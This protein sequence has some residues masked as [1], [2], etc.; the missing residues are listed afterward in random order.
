[1]QVMKIGQIRKLVVTAAAIWLILTSMEIPSVFAH[2]V[3]GTPDGDLSYFRK[4]DH[5]SNPKNTIYAPYPGSA[6]HVPGPLAY[7]WPGSG[8]NTYL[9]DPSLPPGYQSPFEDFEQ[10]PQVACCQYSPEAAILASTSDQDVVGDFV[11]GMN[12]SKP[13]AFPAPRFFR[14]WSMVIYIPAP[15][16]NKSGT[17]EQDGFEPIGINWDLGETTNIVTTLTDSYGNISVTRAGPLDPFGPNWWMIRI[18]AGGKGIVFTEEGNEWYYVR[19]NQMR[20]PVISGRYFF[21]I[22]LDEHYPV[23]NQ[24]D[25]SNLIKATVPVENWPV[26]LVKGDID[27]A[28]VYGTV[29]YGGPNQT[30]YGTPLQLPGRIRLAGATIGLAN[31]QAPRRAVEA[32]GY[33]NASSKGHY[34]VEGVSPGTYDVYASAAGFPEQTVTR[35]IRVM[36]GQS[37]ALDLYLKPGAEVRGDLFAKSVLSSSNWAQEFP[38]NIVIYSSDD[39][40]ENSIVTF[41]PTNLTHSPYTSYVQGNTVF[42]ILQTNP[43]PYVKGGLLASNQPKL[44][45]FPWQGPV[46]Y[47]PYTSNPDA[48]DLYGIFNGVGPAQKWWVSPSGS[49]D[50]VTNLGSTANSFRFQFGARYI[51]GTPTRLSGMIPQ[52]FATWI[53]GLGI[54]TYFLRAYVHEY[55]QTKSDGSSFEDYSFRISSLDQYVGVHVQMDLYRAG[56]VD[57]V[58]HFHDSPGTRQDSNIGG[59]DPTRYI[60]VEAFDYLGQMSALNFTKVASSSS[61]AKISLTGLGMAGVILPPDPRSGVKYSLLRYRGVRDYGLS[62]GA[63]SIRVYVRGYVQASAPGNTLQHL[64][65][66]LICFV[67]LDSYHQVSLHMYRGGGINT[68]VRSVDWQI[69]VNARNWT[70]NNTE[71]STLVYDMASRSFIDVMYFWNDSAKSWR[72]PRTNSQF[73]TIPW[74]DW[75]SKFGPSA[76]Y[77]MTNGSAALERLGPAL[78]NPASPTPTQDMATNLF[79]ENVLRASFLYSS[80]SYRAADFRS[81]VAIYPG[82]YSL[83]AWTYGCVQEGV[84]ALGDLG[85]VSVAIGAIGSHADSNIQLMRGTGFNITMIFRKEGIIEGIPHNSSVRIRIYDDTD[86]LVAAASTSL[87]AGAIDLATESTGFFADQK[88]IVLAGGRHSIPKGTK[89][90]E[91]RN[92]A[93]FYRYTE[94]LTGTEKIQALKKA[95]LF[96]VDCGIWGSAGSRRGYHGGWRVKIDVVNWYFGHEQFHPAPA[97][98]LQGESSFLFSYNHLGPYESRMNITIPNTALGGGASVCVPLDLRAHVRGHIYSIDWVDGVRTTGWA[99]VE[100]RKGKEVYGTYSL[101]G[102]YDTYLP[103]GVYDFSVSLKRLPRREIAANRTISLS[104]GADI[105][106]EDFFLGSYD[107]VHDARSSVSMLSYVAHALLEHCTKRSLSWLRI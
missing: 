76:S 50:A 24:N 80:A 82:K 94:L 30:L 10:P 13:K 99:S 90:L 95:Q 102:F 55:V 57:V 75:K 101:D 86:S 28:I 100:M 87:D 46:S 85:R 7:V 29:R 89:I 38:V 2:T 58:V 5:E 22:F 83:T 60:V 63:H 26:V 43:S 78:S 56:M 18:G 37:L 34:E 12:F 54:G 32:R 4:N 48:K 8:S 45:A 70:W 51:Y 19:I 31:G 71:V 20:A 33:F 14:Y 17:L 97:A 79:L 53:D 11:F 84:Y 15:F 42:D 40:R 106:G 6:G 96:S 107:I 62:P 16:K 104:D 67:S 44:V 9:E 59:P 73:S 105:F 35:N 74:P 47:Y 27:P 61:S 91:Y 81:N 88:K 72:L 49:V 98:L 92:L 65:L 52:I 64:D 41:S 1:M 39:Y 21:K 68:T 3:L 93:G 103:Q 23:R 36:K 69:P 77:L 25:P 66:A